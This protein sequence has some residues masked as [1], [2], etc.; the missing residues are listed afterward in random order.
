M[1]HIKKIDVVKNFF[2]TLQQKI[3]HE[4]ILQ[5]GCDLFL[6]DCWQDANLGS[7]IS[8]II[9]DG[10]VL[11][12]GGINFSHIQGKHLP[13]SSSDIRKDL[14]T[15]PF[16]VMGISVVMHPKNPFAPT[17]HLNLRF[18]IVA[19]PQPIWWFG[20]GFDLTPYYGFEEDCIYWHQMAKKACDQ[21]DKASY[22]IF[23]KACDD[24]FFIKHRNEPRGIGGIFF[25]D[26]NQYDFE[27]CFKFIQSVGENYL[28][29]YKT[30]L[31]RRKNTI[32]EAEQRQFQ[33]YRRGR[34]VEFN[35]L[36]DRGT[37]FGLQ[38]NGRIESIF[39][40]LPPLTTWKY[41][42]HPEPGTAEEKLYSEFLQVKE[43][44]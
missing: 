35:L 26:L 33:L 30:I 34:Y 36:Y 20:G 37:L 11:E 7:G 40:S 38:S 15:L 14:E 12:K 19:A 9:S 24:Y 8:C 5:E 32:Y 16:E 6:R 27:Q 43:W 13:K 2:L 22:P 39:M 28:Q 29:A 18:F 44:V 1:E 42:Y 10:K 21:L 3:Q 17:S 31:Q 25:D 41:N 23:K 4:I